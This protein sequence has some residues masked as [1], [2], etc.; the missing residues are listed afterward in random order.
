MQTC[1]YIK[2]LTGETSTLKVKNTDTFETVKYMYQVKEG[3][4]PN[5]ELL[6]FYAGK[7][8]EDNCTLSDYSIQHEEILHIV[9]KS[10]GRD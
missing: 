10:R 5:Q 8:L 7:L 3:C 4:H 1:I 9:I 2:T 6:L